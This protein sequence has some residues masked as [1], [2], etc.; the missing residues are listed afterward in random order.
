MFFKGATERDQRYEAESTGFNFA[1]QTANLHALRA[2][3]NAPPFP[4]DACGSTRSGRSDARFATKPPHATQA[5]KP[6][7]VAHVERLHDDGLAILHRL[8]A[9]VTLRPSQNRRSRNR[10]PEIWILN[11]LR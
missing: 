2:G 3:R 7:H 8:P 6:A 5:V 10:A 4:G 11:A 9:C 1:L